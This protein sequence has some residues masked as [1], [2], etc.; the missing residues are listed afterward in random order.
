MA[1]DGVEGLPPSELSPDP[2]PACVMNG[3]VGFG[4]ALS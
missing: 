3:V 4:A 2:P 1:R